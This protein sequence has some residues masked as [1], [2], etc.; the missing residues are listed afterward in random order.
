MKVRLSQMKTLMKH[1][2]RAAEL[3]NFDM[4]DLGWSVEKTTRLYEVTE[5]Y[6]RFLATHHRRFTD[7]T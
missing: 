1:V 5:N 6:F 2:K 7:L 4:S 3:V